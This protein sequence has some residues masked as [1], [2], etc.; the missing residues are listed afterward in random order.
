MTSAPEF[1][2]ESLTKLH[3]FLGTLYYETDVPSPQEFLLVGSEELGENGRVLIHESSG[4]LEIGIQFGCAFEKRFSRPY[5][6]GFHEIG[7]VAEE[8][9]HFRMVFLAAQVSQKISVLDLEVMG[10][11]DRFVT[12]LHAHQFFSNV[13]PFE[14]IAQV[15]E[16]I[17][18]QRSFSCNEQ[19]Q[20]LYLCAESVALAHLNKAFSVHWNSSFVDSLDALQK[21][22]SYL[23]DLRNRVIQK[24][25]SARLAVVEAI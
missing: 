10:E 22:R 7:V 25:F 9:S 15:C 6:I 21:A 3:Q 18:S 23:V 5:E 1:L 4:E 20:E 11:I 19:T 8:V 14:S 24:G 16:L 2:E 12:L 17:F 13:R